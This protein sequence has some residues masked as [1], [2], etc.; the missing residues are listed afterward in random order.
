MCACVWR[1]GG[2]SPAETPPFLIPF[3][4]LVCIV[5]ANG[6]A[7]VC[8]SHS[9]LGNLRQSSFREIRFSEAARRLRVSISAREC[10]CTNEIFLWPSITFQ[11]VQLLNAIIRA[12]PWA[13]PTDLTRDPVAPK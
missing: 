13:A 4:N 11:P 10:Y 1:H 8:E 6:D 3:I 12:R 2:L 5:Y 7:S 9:P